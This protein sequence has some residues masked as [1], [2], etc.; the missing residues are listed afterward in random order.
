V[1][2][3]VVLCC[4]V[5]RCVVLC[6][7]CGTDCGWM[8][9]VVATFGR[10]PHLPTGIGQAGPGAVSSSLSGSVGLVGLLL[11]TAVALTLHNLQQGCSCVASKLPSPLLPVQ[12]SS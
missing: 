10:A 12:R 8:L 3:G 4:V 11:V 7:G 1:W 9:H 5:L 6:S 2:C